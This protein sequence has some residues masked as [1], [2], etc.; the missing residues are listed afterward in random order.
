MSICTKELLLLRTVLN[1][2]TEV[3]YREVNDEGTLVLTPHK[4]GETNITVYADNGHE[5]K[6][7]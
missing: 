3:F 2:M 6:L 7:N 4:T 1:L 5:K